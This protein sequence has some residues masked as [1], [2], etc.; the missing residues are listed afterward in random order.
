V[1]EKGIGWA[2]E[3]E[4]R[5]EH[6]GDFELD[7]WVRHCRIVIGLCRILAAKECLKVAIEELVDRSVVWKLRSK[8]RMCKGVEK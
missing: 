1:A 2:N 8:E 7:V 6:D 4:G 5:E 3:E